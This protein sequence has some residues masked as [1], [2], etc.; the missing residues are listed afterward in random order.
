MNWGRSHDLK[1][2]D[3]VIAIGS[4]L[5][6]AFTTTT[7]IVSAIRMWDPFWTGTEVEYVQFDATIDFGNSGGPLLNTKGEVIGINELHAGWLGDLNLAI[8]SDYARDIV[9]SMIRNN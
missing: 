1:V 8:S 3:Q 5:D 9:D 2:G 7:G 4:P 6:L